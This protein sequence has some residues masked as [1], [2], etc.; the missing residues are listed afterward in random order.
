MTG[1]QWRILH[2]TRSLSVVA[3]TEFILARLWIEDDGRI[4]NGMT[5]SCITGETTEALLEQIDKMQRAF[6]LPHIHVVNGRYEEIKP[7]KPET[8]AKKTKNR[9]IAA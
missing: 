6:C 7:E 2:A 9:E 4:A 5:P 8:S 3:K 1:F